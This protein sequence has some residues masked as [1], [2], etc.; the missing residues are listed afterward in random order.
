MGPS[1]G[2]LGRIVPACGEKYTVYKICMGSYGEAMGYMGMV[3]TCIIECC[4]FICC[5]SHEF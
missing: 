5:R 1:V 4:V 3:F 2:D